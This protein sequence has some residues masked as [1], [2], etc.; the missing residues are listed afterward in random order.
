MPE[1]EDLRQWHA[2]IGTDPVLIKRPTAEVAKLNHINFISSPPPKHPLQV[3][4][5]ARKILG[6][7]REIGG[8][9]RLKEVWMRRRPGCPR[10]A[11]SLVL[12]HSHG[13]SRVDG[14]CDGLEQYA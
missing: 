8:F 7:G 11:L 4:K 10:I 3:S 14:T 13:T 12:W 9:N 1:S 2:L 5:K 6:I